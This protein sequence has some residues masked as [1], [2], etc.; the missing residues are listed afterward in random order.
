MAIIQPKYWPRIL[1]MAIPI[2]I[3]MLTQ[4]AINILDT[5]M[6]SWLEPSYAVAGQSALGFS[7]PLLWL[8]GGFLS[9]ISIGTLAIVARR[10]GA[11]EF[12]L[13]GAALTNAV[14]IA[15]LSSLVVGT[16]AYAFVPEIFRMFIDNDAVVAFGVPYA[17]FRLL[18][19]LSMVTTAAIKSF[20]D[21]TNKTY[22]HMVAAIV[23]NIA[24]IVFN[25]LLIFGVGPFPALNVAGAGLASLIATYIGLFIMIGWSFAPTIRKKYQQYRPSQFCPKT[26]WNIIRVS[27]PSGVANIFVMSGFLI[28]FKVVGILDVDSVKNMLLSIPAY[29]GETVPAWIEAQN[30][31]LDSGYGMNSAWTMDISALMI[32]AQPPVYSSSSN[33]L[34]SIMSVAFMG[35]MAFGTATAS[36]VSQSL[37]QKDPKLAQTYAFESAKVASIIFGILGIVMFCMPETIAGWLSSVDDVIAVTASV[38]RLL[39]PGVIVIACAL[40][41]TQSLFGAGCTKFVMVVEGSL[42][43]ICLIPLSYLLGIVFGGGILGM[44]SAV[45]VYATALCLIMFFKLRGDSWKKIIL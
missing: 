39:A 19:V 18:G 27:V 25:Y 23:M 15:V 45:L 9:S 43:F 5:V 38:L 10:Q 32:Q 3:A 21:G 41:F 2:V 42:H 8:F 12:R 35:A 33:L 7:T 20:F 37:G 30:A 11:E 4:T 24:N 28:F 16:L 14:T 26:M 29:A 34:V 6:V 22:V 44:W 13:A 1:Q 36:L 17:R 40:I 31:A